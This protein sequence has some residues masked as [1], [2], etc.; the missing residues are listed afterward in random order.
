MSMKD[1]R[2]FVRRSTRNERRNHLW[3]QQWCENVRSDNKKD[4]QKI[5]VSV[6]DRYLCSVFFLHNL[7][8][9][10]LDILFWADL[11]LT[12]WDFSTHL[13]FVTGNK[14]K[15][16]NLFQ[17]R[18]VAITWEVLGHKF[19]LTC[20]RSDRTIENHLQRFFRKMEKDVRRC[21]F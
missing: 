19:N 11:H 17:V 9:V 21:F 13:R 16:G 20:W 10:F 1:L 8:E 3:F 15:C 12:Q 2:E 6:D 5:Y 18:F 14:N 4:S 7:I